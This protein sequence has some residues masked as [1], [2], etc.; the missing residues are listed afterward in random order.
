MTLDEWANMAEDEPGEL[1]DGRLVEEEGARNLHEAAVSWAFGTLRTWAK[2]RGAR[3][4][5]S[6]HKLGISADRGRKPEE[7]QRVKRD[8]TQHLRG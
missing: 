5:G 4:F 8:A 2:P 3:V 7:A 6:E 1:V